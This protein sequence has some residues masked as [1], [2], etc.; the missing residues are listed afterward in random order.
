[1]HLPNRDEETHTIHWSGSD[2]GDRVTCKSGKVEPDK[3]GR[4]SALKKEEVKRREFVKEKLPQEMKK[5]MFCWIAS[6][7]SCTQFKQPHCQ[8][9]YSIDIWDFN[10]SLAYST[11]YSITNDSLLLYF[12]DGL[13]NGKDTL[14]LSKV[15][16][17]NQRD[18]ICNYL[19]QIKLDTF[20]LKYINPFVEDGDQKEIKFKYGSIDKKIAISN[21]YI[22]SIGDLYEII[23]RVIGD[24]NY[25][26]RF[27]KRHLS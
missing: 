9:S 8:T 26:I 20:K 7:A 13:E 23:N 16:S 21:V 12:L 24:E 2:E 14:L 4:R 15:L 17:D 5:L 18:S 1:M 3:S 27:R 10:S 22:K 11:H 19:S 6:L 25:R